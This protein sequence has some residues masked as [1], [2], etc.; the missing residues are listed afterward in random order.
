METK[1]AEELLFLNK[2]RI[3]LYA[4]VKI[5]DSSNPAMIDNITGFNR[6]NT[7]TARTVIRTITKTFFTSLSPNCMEKS[8]SGYI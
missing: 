6:K 8:V 3:F 7:N 1:N 4:G 5:Q 2:K